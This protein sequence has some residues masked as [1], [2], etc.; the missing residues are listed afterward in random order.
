M[1]IQEIRSAL[2]RYEPVLVERE[3]AR[4]AAVAVV[5]REDRGQPEVLLIHRA[6]KDGDP[7]SGH[8]AFP[9]GR[10][11]PEDES[12]EHAARR[13]TFEE[14]GLPMAS[15]VALGRI[16]DLQGRNAGRPNAMVIS[17]FVFQLREAPPP[18]LV[19]QASEV[20]EAFFFP[21]WE[22][23]NPRHHVRRSFHETGSWEFPG[24]V[25][26]EPDRHVVWG[27]TYR[28]IEVLY[29]AVGRPFPDNWPQGSDPSHPEGR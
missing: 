28:F 20:Q 7:W 18:D 27:L 26:G 5:L 29:A 11:D 2:E 21:L 9:G 25:V 16:D 6:D 8:M 23:G 22:L 10:L 1:S 3:S 12:L 14:V 19:L 17:A 13:E 24:I 4:R 15:A